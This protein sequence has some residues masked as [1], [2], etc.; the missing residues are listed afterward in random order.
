MAVSIFGD[1]AVMPDD[2]MLADALASTYPLWNELKSHIHSEYPSI[3]EEWRHYGKT[4][5]WSHKVI[6]K[7]RNL[8]FLVPLDG[9]FRI[10]FVFGEKAVACIE[11]AELPD[12]I[13]EAIH[14]A[15][16]YTEGRGVDIDIH[17][18]EQ[19]EAVKKLLKIKYEN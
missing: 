8:L 18:V 10:R 16:P 14:A 7:K 1:K 15:T 11:T 12:E 19:L 6:S 13:K 5:G 4:G 9:C 17:R 2:A 3:T